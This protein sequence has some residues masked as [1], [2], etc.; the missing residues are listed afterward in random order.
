MPKILEKKDHFFFGDG[1]AKLIFM[2]RHS[3]IFVTLLDL[4]GKVV[5]C[6]T[7]GCDSFCFNKKRKTSFQAVESVVNLLM[8]FL[9]LY[10]IKK[11]MVLFKNKASGICYRL[12]SYFETKGILVYRVKILLNCPHNGVRGRKLRRI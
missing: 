10:G 11:M 3:N 5:I 4:K 8:P 6:K 9:K 7:S 1:N 2:I 12:L